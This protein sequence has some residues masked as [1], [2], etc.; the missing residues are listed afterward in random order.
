MPPPCRSL[1]AEDHIWEELFARD[2]PHNTAGRP[3]GAAYQRRHATNQ[4]WRLNR[5]DGVETLWQAHRGPVFG[6]ELLKDP[7]PRGWI[8]SGGVLSSQSDAETSELVVWDR[9]S[10]ARP[11]RK[12]HSRLMGDERCMPLGLERR[13]WLGGVGGIFH[14]TQRWV[15]PRPAPCLALP[16]GHLDRSMRR[17][18]VP[19]IVVSSFDGGA[20]VLQLQWDAKQLQEEEEEQGAQVRPAPAAAIPP[21]MDPFAQYEFLAAGGLGG[22]RLGGGRAQDPNLRSRL[23]RALHGHGGPVVSA[24]C[25]ADSIATCSFDGTIRRVGLG[26]RIHGF[27]L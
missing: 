11:E 20:L 24:S 26:G 4:R 6:V 16:C 23:H 10:P 8:V 9:S 27:C 14:V 15:P 19:E 1:S 25:H 2:F 12:W 3:W 7:F 5:P 18:G 13:P 22:L 21:A 17:P